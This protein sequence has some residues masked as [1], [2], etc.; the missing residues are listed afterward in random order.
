MQSRRDAY[1]AKSQLLYLLLSQP[2]T[3]IDI[4]HRKRSE[5][6]MSKRRHS[7]TA[8]TYCWEIALRMEEQV[9]VHHIYPQIDSYFKIF[10]KII[11]SLCL[12]LYTLQTFSLQLQ[13]CLNRIVDLALHDNEER[14][15]PSTGI[16]AEAL[17]P[18]RESVDGG[19]Q[20]R[21]WVWFELRAEVYTATSDYR[22][23]ELV[24]GVEP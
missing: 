1:L 19:R 7:T 22:E 20:I 10:V 18:V 23:V 4:S 17:E 21:P 13:S 6:C 12:H 5:W 24:G 8:S 11:H 3:R 9:S 15:C 2:C 14:T 16:G